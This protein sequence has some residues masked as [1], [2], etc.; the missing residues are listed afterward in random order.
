MARRLLA[1][2]DRVTGIRTDPERAEQLRLLGVEPLVLDLA[3]PGAA[4]RIPS[5]VD[6][7]LAL[8]SA[9]GEGEAAY[10]RAYLEA[11]YTLL[12]AARRQAVGAFVYAGSTGLF[13]QRDGTD[14][15]EDTPPMPGTP[16][17]EILLEAE[18]AI[19]AAVAQGI[20]ARIVRLS[21]LYGP[22][23]LWIIDRV[24]RGLMTLGPGDAAWM[25]ACHQDDAVTTLLAVLDRGRNGG[26]YHATDALPMRRGEVITFVAGRLGF[27]VGRSASG[28]SFAGPNRRILGVRTRQELGITCRWPSLREGLGPFF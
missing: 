7:I 27:Q 11:N 20:P 12:D 9:R 2:G 26:L 1:R 3:D 5:G 16:T 18:R 17:G 10:R 22:G 24:R 13:G 23:R 25:N 15:Q 21:G 14:V 8:Q 28:I 4:A 19:L 6:A